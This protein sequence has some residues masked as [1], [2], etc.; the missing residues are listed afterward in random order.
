M[1]GRSI[2]LHKVNSHAEFR[3]IWNSIHGQNSMVII[4]THGCKSC[5]GWVTDQRDM[6]IQSDLK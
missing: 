4:D 5:I 6:V 3:R 2:F 1:T